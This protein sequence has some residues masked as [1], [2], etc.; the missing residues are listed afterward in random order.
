MHC[1]HI[2]AAMPLYIS[3]DLE[4]TDL[5]AIREHLLSCEPC[6]SLES[7]Y[8]ESDSWFKGLSDV[9]PDIAATFEVRN[10]VN[11]RLD[12]MS[13][14]KMNLTHARIEVFAAHFRSRTAR[15]WQSFVRTRRVSR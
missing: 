12:K 11:R 10:R 7:Q 3:R 8:L 6:R 2:A 4:Q 1:T 9:E 5:E 13:L 15:P 14:N